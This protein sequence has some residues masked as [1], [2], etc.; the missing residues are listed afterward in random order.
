MEHEPGKVFD[1]NNGDYVILGKIIEKLTGKPYEDVLKERILSPLGM[2]GSGILH[3]RDI[4]SNLADTY[5]YRDDIKTLV[6]DLPA[7][8]ENWYAAGAM[9][10]TLAD[11]RTF[12]NAL[13]GGK[14]VTQVARANVQAG[15]RR[16]RFRSCGPTTRRS[17]AYRIKW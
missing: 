14:L 2:T 6:P 7:Y 1:Y 5:F 10:S 13:F 11:L 4:V 16:L 17:T 3:Q 15:A 12:S 9:Y 8:P